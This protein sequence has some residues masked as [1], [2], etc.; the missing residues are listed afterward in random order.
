MTKT[1]GKIYSPQVS[2]QPPQHSIFPKFLRRGFKRCPYLSAADISRTERLAP[3][4][5]GCMWRLSLDPQS[6]DPYSGAVLHLGDSSMSLTLWSSHQQR[7]TELLLCAKLLWSCL[8][9]QTFR[10]QKREQTEEPQ[11]GG[12][13]RMM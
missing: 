12:T 4:Q 5:S 2:A 7:Y 8:Q 3:D 13:D 9:A 10:T 11:S 6:P 1:G